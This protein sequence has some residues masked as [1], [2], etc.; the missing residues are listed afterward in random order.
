MGE[1]KR[2]TLIGVGAVTV[3][4]ISAA[5]TNSDTGREN[6]AGQTTSATGTAPATTT[7][8]AD[9]A[10]HNNA[11][12]WF[13]RHMIPY[14]Q[15]AIELS[16]IVSAKQGIDSRVTELANKI[17]AT[18]GPQLQQMQDWLNHWGNPPMPGTAPGDVQMPAQSSMPGILSKR[19]LDALREANGADASTLFL[20]QMIAHH[21]GA[22]DLAQTEIEE[23]QYPAAVA[24]ARSIVSTQQ[25]EIDTM[26]RILSSM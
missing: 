5:C 6:S 24:L 10:A 21:E 12:V 4:V 2:T 17:R 14:H 20:T 8:A 11:D 23:G 25:Q 3:L 19:E 22:I 9:T 16:D 7:P 1:W 26:K 18:Q 13:V 15:E